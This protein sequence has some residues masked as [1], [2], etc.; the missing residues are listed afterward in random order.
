MKR[1]FAGIALAAR[2][3][4]QLVVERRRLVALRDQLNSPPA[5]STSCYLG[6][7]GLA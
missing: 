2:P 4:A 6:A 7:F 5:A 3:A 1:D